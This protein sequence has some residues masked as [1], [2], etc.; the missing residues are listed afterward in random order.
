MT[1]KSLLVSAILG[2]IILN[3]VEAPSICPSYLFSAKTEIVQDNFFNIFLRECES[4]VEFLERKEEYNFIK[5]IYDKFDYRI[6]DI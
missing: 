2:G 4:K 1:R 6:S 5:G 3:R